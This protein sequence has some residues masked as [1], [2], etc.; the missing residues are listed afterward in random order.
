[1]LYRLPDGT[2]VDLTTITSIIPME[3]AGCRVKINTGF[4]HRY[5]VG[6]HFETMNDARAYADTLTELVNKAS[7]KLS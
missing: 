6:L 2:S 7:T 5:L 4:D 3:D 1:M